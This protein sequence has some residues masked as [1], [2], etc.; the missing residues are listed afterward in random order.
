MLANSLPQLTHAA[1]H[2]HAT[3][4]KQYVKLPHIEYLG[5]QL[6]NLGNEAVQMK[7]KVAADSHLNCLVLSVPENVK[8]DLCLD[9]SDLLYQ[10]RGSG[11]IR[12]VCSPAYL[13]RV[14]QLP[15]HFNVL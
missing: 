8:L 1:L 11:G 3:G 7:V 2:V 5:L 14:Y 4:F 12:Y 9:K 6:V 10:I 13:T 15:K